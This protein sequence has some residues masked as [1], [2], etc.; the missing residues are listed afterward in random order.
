MELLNKLI[1]IT[2]A[3]GFIGGRLAERLIADEGARVRGLVRDVT[4]VGARHS[5]DHLSL[6]NHLPIENDVQSSNSILANA[7]PLRDAEIMIGDVTD[8]DVVRRA[9]DGC[10]AVVHC[11]AMQ[12][13]RAHLDEYRRVNVGGTLNLLRAAREANVERFIH[14]S[15][16]NAHGIPP[17]RNANADSPLSFRGDFY[18]VSKAEGER[19][20]REFANANN[21]PLVVIRPGCTYGPRSQAWTL[22]PL[23]RVRRG[24][25]VLIGGGNGICNAVYIDNLVDLIMLAMKNDAAI[26]LAFIGT[27]G[28][29]VT[30]REFYGAYARML[31]GKQLHARSV[32]RAFALTVTTGFEWLAKLTGYPP[33]I[34]RSSIEFYSH[35]VVFD[36]SN[37]TR[38]LGYQARISFEEGMARTERWLSESGYLNDT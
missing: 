5:Q 18:S 7:S 24:A 20:A 17:P 26:G 38:L 30:W 12:S 32:S 2:G 11:A 1:L 35:Q 13:G 8:A 9:M 36:I 37:A 6:R 21:L 16:I 22:S 29:G 34:A 4:R 33:R 10:D 23:A 25:P 14:I 27:E 3:N 28:R 15:T 31:G 19:A